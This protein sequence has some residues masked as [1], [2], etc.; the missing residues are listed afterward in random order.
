ME[1][2]EMHQ[3]QRM[4]IQVTNSYLESLKKGASSDELAQKK[5]QLLELSHKLDQRNR[6]SA[7]PSSSARRQHN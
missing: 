7:D 3:L 5:A 4:Y 6:G 2:R 1:N